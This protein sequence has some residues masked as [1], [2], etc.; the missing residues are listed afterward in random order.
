MQ[1]KGKKM[2]DIDWEKNP[3]IQEIFK[4]GSLSSVVKIT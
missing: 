4:C 3:K 1:N 2:F